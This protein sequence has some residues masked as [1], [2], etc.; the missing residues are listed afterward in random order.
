MAITTESKE[1]RMEDNVSIQNA[2]S[3]LKKN[4]TDYEVERNTIRTAEWKSSR[5]KYNDD[6]DKTE[7]SLKE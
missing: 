4:M 2:F 6:L 5:N 1:N 3:S 7:E